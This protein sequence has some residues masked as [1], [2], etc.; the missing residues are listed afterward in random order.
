MSYTLRGRCES[1][2]VAAAPAML[3]AF[4]VHRWWAIELVA[5]MLTLGLLLDVLLYHPTIPY[6]P[7]WVAVPLGAGELVLVYICVR[8]LGIAA[9]LRFAFALFAITWVATQ[10][11]T[12]ALFPRLRLDYGESGGELG[13]AGALTGIAV[14]AAL[15]A[16][17]AGAYA[18]LPPTVH[19]HGT[20]R[21]P[22]VID[23]AET[24]VGGIVDGGIRI[25][26][27]HVTLRDVTVVGGVNGIDVE[28]ASHVVLDNVRVLRAGS[29]AIHVRDSS[30]M[31]KNCTVSDPAG[32]WVQGIDISYSMGQAMSMVSG[33]AID[34]V[35]EGIVTHSSEVDVEDNHVHGTTLRGIV[36]GEMSMDMASGNHVDGADGVGILC[37]DHSMCT[38]EHN[39]IIDTHVAA[40]G[41]YSRAGVA[42]E[43]ALLR[44]GAGAHNTVSQARAACKAFDDVDD[45][46]LMPERRLQPRRP[47]RA[48]ATSSTCPGTSRSRSGVR[49]PREGDPRHQ[50]ARRSLRRLRRRAVRLEGAARAPG[51]PRMDAP[52]PPRGSRSAGRRGR[53]HR[54]RPR[55]GPRRGADHAAPR[56]LAALPRPLH[57]RRGSPT[58]ARTC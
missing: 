58:C 13:R 33:C 32:A 50:P 47:H 2:I 14:L 28:H 8:V 34:G 51:P 26:A 9:P 54:H 55:R 22:L 19:L 38:I 40:G 1:R 37:L 39:T 20:V 11:S 29:D 49:T 25:D 57:R 27:D 35:R 36:L 12:H 23:H 10:A 43:V 30:V 48:S 45:H 56:V 31:I 16:G 18:V 21:G 24:L 7:A 15:A 17:V 3:V 6:Q 41:D 5:L 46:A 42:I 53:R 44:T 4:A 52:A